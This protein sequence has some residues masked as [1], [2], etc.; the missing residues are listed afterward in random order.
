MSLEDYLYQPKM[1]KEQTDEVKLTDAGKTFVEII[2]NAA[3][4]KAL[5]KNALDKFEDLSH[6][7]I[8]LLDG[9]LFG[10]TPNSKD[11]ILKSI[12]DGMPQPKA[13]SLGSKGAKPVMRFGRKGMNAEADAP[14]D[15]KESWQPRTAMTKDEAVKTEV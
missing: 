14:Q 9:N 4:S 12:L 3:R 7:Q 13:K 10:L 1:F 8:K 2:A 11:T 5:M 6:E 15:N